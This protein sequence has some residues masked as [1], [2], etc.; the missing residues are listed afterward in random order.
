MK[1]RL[2]KNP[3][4]FPDPAA[5]DFV[6][7]PARHDGLS[8]PAPDDRARA[9]PR[10]AGPDEE[11]DEEPEP[12]DD[13]DETE[14]DSDE[15]EVIALRPAAGGL[16]GSPDMPLTRAAQD[17]NAA[18][19]GRWPG[20]RQQVGRTSKDR[21]LNGSPY[22]SLPHVAGEVIGLQARRGRSAPGPQQADESAT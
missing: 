21:P 8:L 20:R 9:D 17:T 4:F 22:P 16:I 13:R 11:A 12:D 14:D 1:L 19:R 18:N 3:A 6:Q 10:A 15:G 5:S 7:D 2:F